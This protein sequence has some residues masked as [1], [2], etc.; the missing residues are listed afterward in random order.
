MGE[1]KNKRW[2]KVL[3]WLSAGVIISLNIKLV[4]EVVSGFIGSQYSNT[5]LISLIFVVLIYTAFLLGYVLVHPWIRRE[6]A[7]NIVP[8]QPV[9]KLNLE[10]PVKFKRIAITVDF[11][12]QDEAGIQYAIQMGGRDAHYILIHIVESAAAIRHGEDVMDEETNQDKIILQRYASQLI[13]EGINI[14]Y[15]LGFGD[16]AEN[17]VKLVNDSHAELLVMAAHG[18]SG[19]KDLVLGSTVDTVRHKLDIPVLIVK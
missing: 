15:K 8:H 19:I 9:K 14:Q 5:M 10:K 6:R 11:S 17:I 18:H 7:K 2:V 3:A 4:Y 13:D 16:R 1:Y 12:E